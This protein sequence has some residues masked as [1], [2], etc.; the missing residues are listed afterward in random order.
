MR[1]LL[2]K[3]SEMEGCKVLPPTGIPDINLP[4][5]LTEFYSLCGGVFL[6]EGSDYWFKISSPEQLIPSNP[7]ILPEGF[8]ED[9][10]RDDIS[11]KLYIIARNGP[12]QAISINLGDR[13]LG[14]CYDSFW[15]LHATSESSIIAYSFKS[16]L[17]SLVK[18]NGSYPYWLKSNFFKLGHL[19]D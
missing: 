11:N 19:Y 8:D 13:H 10:P 18:G 3:I 4:D 14:Y 9:I 7:A 6:F 16:L 5:D 2:Q 12:E 1:E 15:E 17:N